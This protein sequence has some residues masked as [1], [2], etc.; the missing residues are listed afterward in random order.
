MTTKAGSYLTVSWQIY[1]EHVQCDHMWRVR[2]ATELYTLHPNQFPEDVPIAQISEYNI[3]INSNSASCTDNVTLR[4]LL[5]ENV[6]EHVPYVVCIIRTGSG[7]TS[8]S[9]KSE[10][11]YLN[12]TIPTSET[13]TTHNIATYTTLR[14]GNHF[15]LTPAVSLDIVSDSSSCTLCRPNRG[16]LLLLYVCFYLIMYT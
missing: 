2:V 13:T 3:T 14:R 10:R 11:V 6:I 7:A 9:H 16:H 4:L 8:V 15:T 1:Y 5:T 12:S